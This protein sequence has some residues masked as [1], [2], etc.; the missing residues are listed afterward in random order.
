[1]D[2]EERLDKQINSA[3]RDYEEPAHFLLVG[4][5]PI[6]GQG[7]DEWNLP[8]DDEKIL[9]RKLQPLEQ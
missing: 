4:F 8:K 5:S 9:W 2:K 7:F 3:E 6:S 1:M